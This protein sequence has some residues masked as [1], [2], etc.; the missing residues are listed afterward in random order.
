MPVPTA[1]LKSIIL[2]GVV[3][4]HEEHDVMMYNFLNAF[5]QALIMPETKTGDE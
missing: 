2:I 4:A 5:I 1:A 3:D